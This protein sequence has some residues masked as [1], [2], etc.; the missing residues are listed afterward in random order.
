MEWKR[1]T[2]GSW[3]RCSKLF[4]LF[5]LTSFILTKTLS[6]QIWKDYA[7]SKN[8]QNFESGQ[9]WRLPEGEKSKIGS[10]TSGHKLFKTPFLTTFS[11][12]KTLYN[13]IWNIFVDQ[14]YLFFEFFRIWIFLAIP[15]GR[16]MH[17]G[18]LVI[19]INIV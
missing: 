11:S 19:E 4:I 13:Q 1:W 3:S 7:W 15:G 8:H 18:W 10:L 16:T 12:I 17:P 5:F 6:N 2:F 9:L 14:I